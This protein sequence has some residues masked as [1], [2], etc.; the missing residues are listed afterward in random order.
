MVQ[1]MKVFRYK[2]PFYAEGF[3]KADSQEQAESIVLNK[4]AILRE[5]ID[6]YGLPEITDGSD[7]D[8]EMDSILTD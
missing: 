6:E 4:R 7:F 5:E 8:A 1:D 3:V 2:I